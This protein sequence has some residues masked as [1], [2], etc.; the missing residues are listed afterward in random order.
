MAAEGKRVHGY[1]FCRR[2]YCRRRLCPCRG[3]PHP[4]YQA[5]P[6]ELWLVSHAVHPASENESSEAAAERD[7]AVTNR[8][9]AYRGISG[10]VL[11]LQGLQKNGRTVS[12]SISEAGTERK[13]IAPHSAIKPPRG[14]LR[15]I[16]QAISPTQGAQPPTQ[17]D[18]GRYMTIPCRL[19]L[20]AYIQWAFRED[21]YTPA[22]MTL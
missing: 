8:D 13:L 2:H 20:S 15:K 22:R 9:R 17:G 6:Q 16:A 19:S 10:F 14:P 3:G 11:L 12:Q 1:S 7:R 21:S 5:I 18:A 4:F